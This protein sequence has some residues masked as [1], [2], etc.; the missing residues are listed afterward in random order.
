MGGPVGALGFGAAAAL[1]CLLV[2]ASALALGARPSIRGASLAATALVLAATAAL[3][4]RALL[5]TAW[6][7]EA[8]ARTVAGGEPALRSDLVSSV[9]L[10][11]GTGR[12]PG[13]RPFSLALVDAHLTRTAER[14]RAVVLAHVDPGPPRARRAPRPRRRRV[15]N[16]VALLSSGRRALPRLR[17]AVRERPA[18]PGR[19]GPDHGRHRAHLPLPRVHEARAAHALRHRGRDPAPRGTEVEL[20]TR[21]DRKVEAAELE[22]TLE[23]EPADSPFDFGPER[24]RRAD[25]FR[26]LRSG[27][28]LSPTLSPAARGRGRGNGGGARTAPVSAL[29]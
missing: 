13:V 7:D 20:R 12:H 19:G 14:A 1:L 15:V 6:S 10:Y 3:A 18:D 9:E 8:A 24:E 22:V 16:V 26:A 11:P 29:L 27:R 17:P 5:R 21:A 25:R 4:V 28:P 23:A 2:G